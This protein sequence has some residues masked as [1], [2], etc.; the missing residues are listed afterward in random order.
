MTLISPY[1]F[2][3]PDGSERVST[4][5]NMSNLSEFA[6]VLNVLTTQYAL[7]DVDNF[8]GTNSYPAVV[9]T[10]PLVTE[11]GNT[12]DPQ[13]E[14]NFMT[15]IVGAL[16]NNA[17][18]SFRSLTNRG[19][20]QTTLF[21]ARVVGYPGR[22]GPDDCIP[23]PD[24]L[25]IEDPVTRSR[26]RQH[27]TFYWWKSPEEEVP[28]LAIGDVVMVTFENRDTFDNGYATHVIEKTET[29]GA[30]AGDLVNIAAD[31]MSGYDLRALF[32]NGSAAQILAA[33]DS[34][35]SAVAASAE[36]LELVQPIVDDLCRWTGPYP[37]KDGSRTD[38]S[39]VFI[40][41]V[42]VKESE[43]GPLVLLLQ[44]MQR[45][46]ITPPR[47][48]SGFR[49]MFANTV[50]AGGSPIGQISTSDMQ[51]NVTGETT[52]ANCKD[53]DGRSPSRANEGMKSQELLMWRNC[54]PDR[55]KRGMTGYPE[56]FTG[57]AADSAGTTGPNACSPLTSRPS[58]TSPH[59]TGRA[60]DINVGSRGGINDIG[61]AY[62]WLIN[63]AWRYGFVRTVRSERW[64][65]EYR[66]GTSMFR[67]VAKDH[68]TWNS[69]FTTAARAAA[70]VPTSVAAT[71]PVLT[72]EDVI[73]ST[74][75]L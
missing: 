51:G 38:I 29:P 58:S 20:R 7:G 35:P 66:P 53:W 70:S 31:S 16:G 32:S 74:G 10:E 75:D 6:S 11:V 1:T 73:A 9:M 2:I 44:G 22:P 61:D 27:K 30:I 15:S 14:E 64:H 72:Q 41:G 63:N 46:G 50:R 54:N 59:G 55:G 36:A 25:N 4:S 45:D 5:M 52:P 71:S 39:A 19:I 3:S 68:S 8:A 65:W 17:G 12:D 62:M 26:L 23:L 21:K 57:R 13:A 60:I 47:F 40:Q 49:P 69:Y 67:F 48:N 34:G 33:G 18:I 28:T 43:A 56:Y 37:L 24:N 42:P